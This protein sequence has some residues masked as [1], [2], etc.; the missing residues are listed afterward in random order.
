MKVV[1]KKS[2]KEQQLFEKWK[3]WLAS[4]E[5]PKVVIARYRRDLKKAGFAV[6]VVF[7]L[8]AQSSIVASG[9][10]E[11]TIGETFPIMQQ[12]FKEKEV[13]LGVP[14]FELP[15]EQTKVPISKKK[16][17]FEKIVDFIK[18]LFKA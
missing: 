7:S 3:G 10:D 4:Y 1:P 18:K 11:I 15:V 6:M 12:N 9:K 14:K 2:E 17:L 16:S 8:N 5:V 13:S